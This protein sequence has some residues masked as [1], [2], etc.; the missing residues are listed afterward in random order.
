[1]FGRD[2]HRTGNTS[3]PLPTAPSGP[4]NPNITNGR[5]EF[6]LVD[7]IGQR[8]VVEQSE[9][10]KHWIAVSTNR[11]PASFEQAVDLTGL[12]FFR[13]RPLRPK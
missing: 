13:M 11:A 12:R 4:D 8:L 9:D 5:F 6:R 10:L 1:M 2:P 7:P 3:L